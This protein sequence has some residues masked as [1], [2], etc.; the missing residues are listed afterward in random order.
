[1][2][3]I[4]SLIILLFICFFLA[5]QDDS[6]WFLDKPILGFSFSGLVTV[7]EVELQTLLEDYIGKIFN[8]DL[9]WEIQN[10]LYALD[11]FESVTADALPADEEIYGVI[12]N[13]AIQ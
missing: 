13:F 1:M 3:K 11:Y 7:A 12:I 8:Y 4:V 2:K 9:F 6:N 5:A 10:R